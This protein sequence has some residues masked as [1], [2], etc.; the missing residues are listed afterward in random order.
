MQP[1][2]T[3]FLSAAFLFSIGMYSCKRDSFDCG[4]Y[5]STFMNKCLCQT[6]YSGEHCEVADRCITNGVHCKNEGVC[7]DGSCGCVNFYQGEHCEEYQPN[8]LPGAYEMIERNVGDSSGTEY[9]SF[10][11][12]NLR[13]NEFSHASPDRFSGTVTYAV[14]GEDMDEGYV[15]SEWGHQ[16]GDSDLEAW[17]QSEP[18]YAYGG[19]V[20][21]RLKLELR[22][23]T[24]YGHGTIFK[25][26]ARGGGSETPMDEEP[27]S[28]IAVRRS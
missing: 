6:G 3:L 21:F 28:I 17:F 8:L 14:H 20:N 25:L 16:T 2:T 23:D 1:K 10:W 22:D 11:L 4:E 24:L 19:H 7:E 5:G 18:I 15:F 9:G 12:H 13:F 26:G 27:L